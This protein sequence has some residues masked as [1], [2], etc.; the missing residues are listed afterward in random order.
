MFDHAGLSIMNSVTVI[1]Y[2]LFVHTF[3]R[4]QCRD[5]NSFVEKLLLA[6]TENDPVKHSKLS[7]VYNYHIT[8][9][10]LVKDCVLIQI[11]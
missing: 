10:M 8:E 2:C 1:K 7:C 6:M 3:S 5:L 4:L 11:F 9:E